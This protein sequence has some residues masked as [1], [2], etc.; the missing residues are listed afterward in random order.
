MAYHYHIIV[1]A[2]VVTAPGAAPPTHPCHRDRCE[3]HLVRRRRRRR[4]PMKIRETNELAQE[5]GKWRWE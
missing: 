2:I 1:N 3:E 4:S 5:F